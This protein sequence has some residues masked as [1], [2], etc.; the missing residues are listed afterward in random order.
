[1]PAGPL[2]KKASFVVDASDL[3]REVGRAAKITL[4]LPAAELVLVRDRFESVELDAPRPFDVELV[5]SRSPLV[6]G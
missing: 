4:D 3:V 5:P 1:M 6:S 2:A